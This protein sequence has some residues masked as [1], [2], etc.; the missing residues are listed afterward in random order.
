MILGVRTMDAGLKEAVDKVGGIRRLARTIGVS[1]VSIIRW[2]KIPIEYLFVIEKVTDIP[3]ER[4][5]PDIFLF[6]RPRK[7]K[8]RPRSR[9]LAAVE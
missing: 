8:S 5:R 2:D 3:R 9:R 1:H 4:L 7:R 6:P